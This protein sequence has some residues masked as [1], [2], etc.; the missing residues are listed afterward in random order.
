VNAFAQIFKTLKAT[1]SKKGFVV[2]GGK[3]SIIDWDSKEISLEKS[4]KFSLL[5]FE[6]AHE[7]GHC[8]ALRG[9]A[10]V[11]F[12]YFFEKRDGENP[13]K[14]RDLAHFEKIFYEVDAW[15]SGSK[16]IPEAL[17]GAYSAHAGA[18]LASY[19]ERVD[20]K[21]EPKIANRINRAPLALKIEF[22]K[23]LKLP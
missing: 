23:L 2:K 16:F 14:K 5:A 18:C 3:T 21:T 8:L 20:Y 19:L 1:A 22:K 15:V 17:H 4:L 6:F 12:D 13:W 11:N 7:V 10:L 9:G